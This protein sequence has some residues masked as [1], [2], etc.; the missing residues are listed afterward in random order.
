MKHTKQIL[1]IIL[2]GGM[3]SCENDSIKP[4]ENPEANKVMMIAP[5]QPESIQNDMVL[6]VEAPK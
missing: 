3:V 4:K 2:L 6:S 5:P 1:T